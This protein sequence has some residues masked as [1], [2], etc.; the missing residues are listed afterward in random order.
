MCV[1]VCVKRHSLCASVCVCEEG[2]GG[3]GWGRGALLF[4]LRICLFHHSSC[5]MV[6]F[7]CSCNF[8]C[9]QVSNRTEY[10]S[11]LYYAFQNV[12]FPLLFLPSQTLL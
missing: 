12:F 5:Q 8:S 2:V 3:G 7:I 4:F 1:C 10:F 11:T 6:L 9:C